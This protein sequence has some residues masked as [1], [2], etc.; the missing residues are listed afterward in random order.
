MIIIVFL[1][2]W[3]FRLHTV[4]NNL[5]PFYPYTRYFNCTGGPPGKAVNRKYT[6]GDGQVADGSVAEVTPLNAVDKEGTRDR[7]RTRGLGEEG[8]L[9]ALGHRIRR[10]L[11]ECLALPLSML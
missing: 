11:G 10:G 3:L 1:R 9:S 8:R 2:I 4:I 6:D 5:L 7:A